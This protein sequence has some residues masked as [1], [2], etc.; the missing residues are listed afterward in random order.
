MSLGE[1]AAWATAGILAIVPFVG[2]GLTLAGLA[3]G[4]WGLLATRSPKARVGLF[5]VGAALAATG[6]LFAYIG[7]F[8]EV[9]GLP[10][11]APGRL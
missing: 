3:V 4:V 11:K 9:H 7:P 8:L 1:A 10:P 2:F 6:W 5:L